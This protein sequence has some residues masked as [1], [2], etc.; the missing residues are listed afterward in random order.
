MKCLI[1]VTPKAINRGYLGEIVIKIEN[2]AKI[3][4]FKMANLDIN[5]LSLKTNSLE[6]S[7]GLLV[8][9]ALIIAESNDAVELG[10]K[11]REEYGPT[12]VHISENSEISKYEI[13]RFFEKKEIFE[14]KKVD[15]KVFE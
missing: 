1:I 15:E 4:G 10:K 13:E 8:P 7:A 9:C 11:I 5:N 2:H 3:I 14:H 6:N 12:M